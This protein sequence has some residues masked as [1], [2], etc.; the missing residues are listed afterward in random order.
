MEELSILTRYYAL[1]YHN[2]LERE[3]ETDSHSMFCDE[4]QFLDECVY[5]AS[6]ET[7]GRT[8]IT[9][10]TLADYLSLKV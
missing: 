7:F 1:S 10:L 6:E 8:S 9:K 3:Y 5:N 4:L 2:K